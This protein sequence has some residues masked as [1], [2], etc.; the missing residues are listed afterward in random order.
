MVGPWISARTQ[1][2]VVAAFTEAGAAIAPIYSARDIVEDPHVR[3]TQILTEVPDGDL[4]DLLQHNVMWR[5]SE[6]PGSI[7]FTGRDHGADTDAVL[8]EIGLDPERLAALR[9]AGVIA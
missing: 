7:R 8:G 3:E 1:D 2:E 4:G 5:T 9:E 6:T